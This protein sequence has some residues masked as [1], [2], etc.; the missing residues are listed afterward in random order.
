[1]PT[2]A[3]SKTLSDLL[4]TRQMYA[5]VEVAGGMALLDG[6]W[7]LSHTV[8]NDLTLRCD[9][10]DCNGFMAWDLSGETELNAVSGT[11]RF[12]NAFYRCRHCR[13]SWV[14][15]EL[16]TRVPSDKTIAVTIHGMYPRQFPNISANMLAA[17]EDND[18][19]LYLHAIECRAAGMGLGALAYLRRVVEN[20]INLL[21][22][23]LA[24]ILADSD[25]T[26]QAE[27]VAQV[28]YLK[29]QKA[30]DKKAVA[31]AAV[32]PKS[33]FAGGHNP[34]SRLHDWASV[35]V[36]NEPDEQC[37]ELFDEVRGLFDALFE[38]L[39]AEKAT[40]RL[41]AE[42]L[43]KLSRRVPSKALPKSE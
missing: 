11:V 31:A 35:G 3:E 40:R 39:E 1:M 33:F 34:F 16:A 30:F 2:E 20:G 28:G 12:S 6:K 24:S 22:D 7:G 29:S 42:R 25:D 21:L 27:Y 38:R 8:P 4:E 26:K 43:G 17:L 37:C 36:H 23:L 32:L 10:V 19:V 15:Y 13:R 41:Y 14:R 9:D 5:S 18:A